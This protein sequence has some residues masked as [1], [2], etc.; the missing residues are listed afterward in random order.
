MLGRSDGEPAADRNS[1]CS[2]YGELLTCLS[3]LSDEFKTFSR[4]SFLHRCQNHWYRLWKCLSIELMLNVNA[5]LQFCSQNVSFSDNYQ[6]KCNIWKIWKMTEEIQTPQVTRKT[7]N[8]HG[9]CDL[10]KVTCSGL[11]GAFK[12]T[13]TRT[14]S[15]SGDEKIK[16]SK[17]VS[18]PSLLSR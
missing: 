9:Y 18:T 13:N 7:V 11:F 8:T 2:G 5:F 3:T 10:W 1:L 6:P 17:Y 12:K 15:T 4:R 14:R 16:E